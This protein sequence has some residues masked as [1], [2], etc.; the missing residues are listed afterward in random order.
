MDSVFESD[1]GVVLQKSSSFKK[2]A[3]ELSDVSEVA[4]GNTNYG[5][6]D[7]CNEI[8]SSTAALLE[9]YGNAADRDAKRLVSAAVA[10]DNLDSKLSH[11]MIAPSEKDLQLWYGQDKV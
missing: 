6:N 10:F 11:D 1:V 4:R 7:V 8:Y 5:I 2:A 3:G 9:A